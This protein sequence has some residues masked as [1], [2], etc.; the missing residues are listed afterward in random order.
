MISTPTGR[1]PLPTT[2]IVETDASTF[3]VLK[4]KL[5]ELVNWVWSAVMKLL[6]TTLP[7]I[8]EEAEGGENLEPVD[9]QSCQSLEEREKASDMGY[10]NNRLSTQKN[11]KKTP[12]SSKPKKNTQNW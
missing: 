1:V 11:L 4:E 5:A 12:E 10:G 7:C 2:S 9:L 8:F 3:V 6:Q